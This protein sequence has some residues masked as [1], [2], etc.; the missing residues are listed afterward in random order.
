MSTKKIPI[1]G[2]ADNDDPFYRYQRSIVMINQLKNKSEIVNLHTVAK[3]LERE[4]WMIEEYIK[5]KLGINLIQKGH[6]CQTTRTIQ[7]M[8]I[9]LIIREFTEYFILCP[10]CRL[11]ETE[12][13]VEKDA[14]VMTCRSCSCVTT[15]KTVPDK[16]ANKVL[17]CIIKR[18]VKK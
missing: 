11:P 7:P 17:E 16:I 9:E 5:K 6:A 8:E 4:P 18:G 15:L 14:Y 13:A 3:D 1:C 12:Y 10:Q 2:L